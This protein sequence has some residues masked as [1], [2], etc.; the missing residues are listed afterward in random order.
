VCVP[1]APPTKFNVPLE[2][3][4]R[5]KVP[6]FGYQLQFKSGNVEKEIVTKEQIQQFLICLY[7]GRTEDGKEGFDV[8]KG[9]QLD[10]IGKLKPSR[11][12]SEAVCYYYSFFQVNAVEKLMVLL[13]GNELLYR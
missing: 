13:Q 2:D 6:N 4:V 7:G 12:L 8:T 11:L 9:I 3:L 1:Y 5:T 10:K